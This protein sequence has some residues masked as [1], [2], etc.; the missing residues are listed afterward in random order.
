LFT[1]DLFLKDGIPVF[2][3]RHVIAFA[4]EAV[5]GGRIGQSTFFGDVTDDIFGVL[6]DEFDCMFQAQVVDIG[7]RAYSG[8]LHQDDVEASSVCAR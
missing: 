7:G 5:E 8:T 1:T 3:G 2:V 4:E 6:A